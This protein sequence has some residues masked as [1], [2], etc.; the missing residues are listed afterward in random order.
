M[1]KLEHVLVTPNGPEDGGDFGP[2]TTGT[3]TSGIQEALD[4]AKE[5][6]KDV[7]IAGGG[8]TKA[9]KGGVRYVLDET[10]RIPWN[11]NWRVDGGEYWLIYR[12]KRGDAVVIDSQMNCRIKMGLV[13]NAQSPDARP[14]MSG[15]QGTGQLPLCCSKYIRI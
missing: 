5:N 6:Q 12:P 13:V 2:K 8:L 14:H 4:F 10:L 15:I 7:Y 1:N 11:Q 9:F 3:K